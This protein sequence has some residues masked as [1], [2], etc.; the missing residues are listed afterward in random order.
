MPD[1][2]RRLTDPNR[3]REFVDWLIREW[4]L[5]ASPIVQLSDDVYVRF[6][7]ALDAALRLSDGSPEMEQDMFYSQ[8]CNRVP[9]T[10]VRSLVKLQSWEARYFAGSGIDMGD[11]AQWAR[12]VVMYAIQL[13]VMGR[14]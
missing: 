7:C 13:R 10:N 12:M 5:T 1:E 9:L 8:I 11:W 2:V 6:A 4:G 3:L 14:W